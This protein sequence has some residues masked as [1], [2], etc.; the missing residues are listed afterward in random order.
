MRK[1]QTI[2]VTALSTLALSGAG[3]TAYQ[4]SQP[5]Q[6]KGATFTNEKQSTN[7]SSDF[8]SNSTSS[9]TQSQ[10]TMGSS[11][12]TNTSNEPSQSVTETEQPLVIYENTAE[13]PPQLGGCGITK[14][15]PLTFSVY[16]CGMADTNKGR[17]EVGIVLCNELIQPTKM[18]PIDDCEPFAQWMRTIASDKTDL[19]NSMDSNYNYWV[20]NVKGQ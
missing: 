9:S 19:N 18:I 20:Q 2:A 8:N 4:V 5:A 3:F 1:W 16:T 12:D 10:S 6:Y 7:I 14:D 17:M 11:N 13:R 15:V